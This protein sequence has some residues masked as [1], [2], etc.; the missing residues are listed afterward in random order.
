ME[1]TLG[2]INTVPDFFSQVMGYVK[3]SKTHFVAISWELLFL[4]ISKD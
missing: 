1:K 4:S 3:D 2:H